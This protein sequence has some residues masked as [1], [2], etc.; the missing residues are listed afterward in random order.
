[1]FFY[2]VVTIAPSDARLPDGGRGTFR[3]EG[4]PSPSGSLVRR[5]RRTAT[6]TRQRSNDS[7]IC[8]FRDGSRTFSAFPS[9]ES[10]ISKV[11]KPMSRSFE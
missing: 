8:G 9:I 1:V 7:C 2:T 11:S 3:T 4:T 10:A 6:R 5:S